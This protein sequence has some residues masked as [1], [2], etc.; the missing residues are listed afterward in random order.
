NPRARTPTGEPR[1]KRATSC[2]KP[3]RVARSTD[4]KPISSPPPPT[5]SLFIRVPKSTAYSTAEPASG[6]ASPAWKSSSPTVKT[7]TPPANYVLSELICGPKL[8]FNKLLENSRADQ[9]YG[10]GKLVELKREGS[11]RSR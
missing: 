11:R 9:T 5:A 3:K 6:A 4:R 10:R 2:R 8:F 7:A 1:K